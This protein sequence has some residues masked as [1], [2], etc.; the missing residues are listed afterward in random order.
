MKSKCEESKLELKADLILFVTTSILAQ[1]GNLGFEAVS[2]NFTMVGLAR[3]LSYNYKKEQ[4]LILT[5]TR[6]PISRV[7]RYTTAVK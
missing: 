4:K 7:S 6:C 2:K 5:N 3:P 1:H